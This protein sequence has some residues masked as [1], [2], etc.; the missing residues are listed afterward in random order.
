MTPLADAKA[1]EIAA[2]GRVQSNLQGRFA[3]ELS[4]FNYPL[5]TEQAVF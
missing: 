3:P 4:T 1:I 5:S 2:V